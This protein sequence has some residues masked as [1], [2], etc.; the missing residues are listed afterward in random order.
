MFDNEIA[1]RPR[2]QLLVKLRD[3]AGDELVLRFLNFYGSQVKQMAVGARLR[4]RGDV[5]GGFFGLE[6]VHPAVRP[7]MT[8]RPCRKRSRRSIRARRACRRRICAR[9]STTRSSRTVAAGTAAGTRSPSAYLQPLGVPPLM[10]AV[11]TLHHP[12]ADSDETALIDGTHPAWTR[13]KF[14]ELLAQQLSL[15]RAHEERRTRAAPAHAAPHGRR[16]RLAGRAVPEGAA[17]SA[18]RRAAARGAARS[19]R[20]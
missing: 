7:S 12:S 16:S 18:D 10:Q 6:M 17:V 3:D 14:E 1:Y 15:K 11:S 4:V 20:I 13:I 5:R 2:R 8:I 19:R 9:R